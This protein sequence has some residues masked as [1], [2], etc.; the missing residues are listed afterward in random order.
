MSKQGRKEARHIL[1][2]A[3]LA[4]IRH[5][6]LISRI[7][8]ERVEKGMEKMAAIGYCM[9][10]ILRIIYGM[11][12][13]NTAFDPT[14]DQK[15]REKHTKQKRVSK[16]KNRRI[17]DY[18]AKAPV[19]RRQSVKRKERNPS[20]GDGITVNGI[21]APFQSEPNWNQHVCKEGMRA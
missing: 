3:A 21:E 15:N 8:K 19:S 16:D 1:F 14:I 4:S 10:K 9:H 13:S 11:L 6:P 12:K 5:N 20:Q 7:Y 18:D 2:M 17:Q